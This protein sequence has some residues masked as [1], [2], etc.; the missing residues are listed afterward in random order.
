MQN[1]NLQAPNIINAGLVSSQL[2]ALNATYKACTGQST[3][4]GIQW[5]G[6]DPSNGNRI[7]NHMTFAVY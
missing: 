5:G 1:V 7:T 2:A 6:V 4:G 3:T